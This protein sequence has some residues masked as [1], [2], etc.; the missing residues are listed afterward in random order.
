ME[1]REKFLAVVRQFLWESADTNPYTSAEK[2]RAL[3]RVI[4]NTIAR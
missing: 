3:D 2:V 1:R 4:R